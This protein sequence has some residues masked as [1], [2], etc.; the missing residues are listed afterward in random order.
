[1]LLSAVEFRMGAYFHKDDAALRRF[2]YRTVIASHINASTARIC[3]INGVIM[4]N[5]VKRLIDK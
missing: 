1:M 2:K 4:K 5:W 3:T